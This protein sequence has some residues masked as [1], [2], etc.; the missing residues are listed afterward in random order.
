MAIFFENVTFS[1]IIEQ[2]TK[3]LLLL[4]I[5]NLQPKLHNRHDVYMYD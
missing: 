2:K 1:Q 5:I 3:M 4:N